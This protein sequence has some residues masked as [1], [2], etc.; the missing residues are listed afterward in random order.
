[1]S[2]IIRKVYEK[3]SRI[4]G[5]AVHDARGYE[6]PDP[7]PM[8]PA[9]GH[10]PG[11]TLREQIRDMIA[12]ERLAQEAAAAG[13]ETLEEADDF[14]VGDDYDPVT[15]YELDRDLPTIMELKRRKDEAEKVKP[16]PSPK[17]KETPAPAVQ[18]GAPVLDPSGIESG[19]A[20]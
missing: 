14:D 6:L 17:P 5:E 9:V 20:E 4:T 2:S 15:P 8:S 7:T 18:A 11:P 1:M 10:K 13:F 16:A 19:E 3:F 12:S